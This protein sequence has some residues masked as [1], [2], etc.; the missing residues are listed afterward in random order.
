MKFGE[1]LGS[2]NGLVLC[3]PLFLLSPLESRRDEL[4]D[5]MSL[6]NGFNPVWASNE[7]IAHCL[8]VKG[9]L[10][11]CDHLSL[12]ITS[13]GRVSFY[14]HWKCQKVNRSLTVCAW[15]LTAEMERCNR[16]FW[17][18]ERQPDKQIDR[19][20]SREANTELWQ[21]NPQ[22]HV[23]MKIV[24]VACLTLLSLITL[25]MLKFMLPT[26]ILACTILVN[27]IAW[28][29]LWRSSSLQFCLALSISLSLS[30]SL[31]HTHL[32]PFLPL[33]FPPHC[34]SRGATLSFPWPLFPECSAN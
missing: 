29:C 3:N 30:L 9:L 22:H 2:S 20:A 23:V 31:T 13:A 24:Y 26:E 21:R 5:E 32:S 10:S 28:A 15:T 16:M 14:Q 1:V 12:A 25:I 19:Q 17:E 7:D 4:D 11:L 34:S 27:A 18:R 8:K 6:V 33:S